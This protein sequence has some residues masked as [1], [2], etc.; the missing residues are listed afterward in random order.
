[1]TKP[2]SLFGS[3]GWEGSVS[4]EEGKC[5]YCFYYV[6]GDSKTLMVV[7]V[8]PVEKNVA[9]TV[10]SL[11]FAQRVRAVELG[12]ASKKIIAPPSAERTREWEMGPSSSPLKTS[13][14]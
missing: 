5:A 2:S 11:T 9:E 12:Q 6:G 13:C 4:V 10:C 3:V 14:M 7:Q 1:V 8:A